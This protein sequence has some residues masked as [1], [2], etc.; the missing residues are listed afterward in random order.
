[1]QE[2]NNL[3]DQQIVDS[4]FSYINQLTDDLIKPANNNLTD[5]YF[6][7]INLMARNDFFLN[8]IYLFSLCLRRKECPSEIKEKI[9]SLYNNI[10]LY[11][12]T[13]YETLEKIITGKSLKLSNITNMNDTKECKALFEFFKQIIQE[14]DDEKQISLSEF[15]EKYNEYT[16]K[17][18]SFSFSGLKD[19]AAQ[20][21]RY[22]VKKNISSTK[23]SCGVCIEIPMTRLIKLVNTLEDQNNPQQQKNFDLV[24]IKPILYVPSYDKENS[25]LNIVSR[26][27]YWD[28]EHKENGDKIKEIC[29]WSATIKHESF[30][31]EYEMRL[32]VVLN[33]PDVVKINGSILIDLDKPCYE[34]NNLFSSI[35]L[36]PETPE[37]MKDEVIKLLNENNI[38]V[39]PENITL[40]N[41]PL[42]FLQNR[43]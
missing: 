11:H 14:S 7:E 18:F 10:K 36:G 21:E 28:Y 33:L 3:Q 25:M 27:A 16:S 38:N 26:F 9:E 43:Q 35:T 37:K 23:E 22:G 4:Y 29:Q 1:M 19:D 41:C 6:K 13:T 42:R 24:A 30:K 5:P 39:N 15:E 17:I 34:F 32:L 8:N 40:S 31:R 2:N 12:Y 20:W